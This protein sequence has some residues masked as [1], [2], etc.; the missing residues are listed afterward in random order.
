MKTILF[1]NARDE[2]NILEW[3]AHYINL[4][5]DTIYIYDHVSVV[6]I[7]SL[8]G[9][10]PIDNSEH[11]LHRIKV[12]YIEGSEPLKY[13]KVN[14]MKKAAE[15]AKKHKYDWMAYFDADEFLYFPAD[16][17]IK[18]FIQKYP[19][20]HQI[21][22][23]WLMFGSNNLETDP[24]DGIL[25]NY[26]KSDLALDKHI[27]CIVRVD[28]IKTISNPH[29]FILKDN[30]SFTNSEGIEAPKNTPYWIET[31]T[32]PSNVPAYLAH[33]FSQSYTTYV[34]R[35][36]KK[37]MDNAGIFREPFDKEYFHIL[38]NKKEN[39]DLHKYD[40]KNKET[41]ELIKKK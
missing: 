41:I 7:Q 24:T 12:E 30:L 33:Y 4:G 35:K 18:S 2:D 27:K 29:F 10:P 6:P 15:Y 22:I 14:L 36:L 32:P 1:C 23:N 38:F 26:T 37:P 31:S 28:S 16:I 21:G 34:E 5:F 25:K 19:D 8:L 39:T 17:D 13:R 11:P 3:I 20:A 40:A 9:I